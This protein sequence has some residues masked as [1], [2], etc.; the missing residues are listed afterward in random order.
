[1]TIKMNR[2]QKVTFNTKNHEKIFKTILIY[3]IITFCSVD[4]LL[5]DMFPNLQ[6][7]ID[8]RDISV[9]I[10]YEILQNLS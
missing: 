3:V 6:H 5:L 1:M 7:M 9:A 2:N 4:F 8:Y 10:F